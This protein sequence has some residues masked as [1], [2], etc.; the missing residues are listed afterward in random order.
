MARR[1]W[2]HEAES[3][4][5][6]INELRT[7]LTVVT[8]ERDDGLRIAASHR[9]DAL[10]LMDKALALTRERDLWRGRAF[11]LQNV[12]SIEHRL[13]LRVRGQLEADAD[14]RLKQNI[15]RADH[16]PAFK[17]VLEGMLFEM[18]SDSIDVS[19]LALR[20]GVSAQA[21]AAIAREL[22]VKHW[23]SIVTNTASQD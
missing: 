15:R 8:K 3:K 18:D 17:A 12:A 14:R 4:I 2:K 7:R 19:T 10:E 9:K 6:T 16:D 13:S 23:A 20:H 11:G 5:E 22:D 1:D 21:C